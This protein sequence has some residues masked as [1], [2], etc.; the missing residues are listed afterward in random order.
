MIHRDIFI[1]GTDT[2]VGKT[3]LSLL[4]MQYYYAKG[5]NPFYIKPFQTGCKDPYDTDSD[6]KFIYNHAQQLKGKNPADSLVYIHKNPK[7]PYFAARDQGETIDLSAVE[8]KIDEKRKH[9]N[10]LI[11]E[12][13]GGLMVPV[14]D[15]KMVVDIIKQTRATTIVAARA[16]LGTINHTLLTIEALRAREIEIAGVFFIDTG[17]QPLVPEKMVRENSEAIE[18]IS[19]VKVAGVIGR[20]DDFLNPNEEI[21]QIFNGIAR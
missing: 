19:G 13:A 9:H 10:P 20:I 15:D 16:G 5:M 1:T 2:G 11:I 17:A 3:V 4:L 21:Y 6:A 14:T 7:A 8:K 18:N 12:G